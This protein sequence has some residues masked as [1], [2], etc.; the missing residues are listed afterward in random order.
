MKVQTIPLEA[1][2]AAREF[3]KDCIRNEP[4][5]PFHRDELYTPFPPRLQEELDAAVSGGD[6]LR[7]VMLAAKAEA[8]AACP[9]LVVDVR[10]SNYGI[11]I[12]MSGESEWI[13]AL[14]YA[15]GSGNEDPSAK[16]SP[17]AAELLERT[18]CGELSSAFRS[19]QSV[20]HRIKFFGYGSYFP[21]IIE[22]IRVKK[23]IELKQEERVEKGP[24]QRKL[25]RFSI[26]ARF[27]PAAPA[28]GYNPVLP[29]FNGQLPGRREFQRWFSTMLIEAPFTGNESVLVWS[30]RTRRELFRCFPKSALSKGNH[31]DRMFSLLS[32]LRGNSVYRVGWNLD[33]KAFD[34]TVNALPCGTWDEAK[35]ALKEQLAKPTSES[36]FGLSPPAAVL[37][38]W[39]M[40]L[41][42]SGLEMGL[43]PEVE[44][45]IRETRLL[46]D[47]PWASEN[48][49]LYLEL[50]AEEV[51]DRTP[52][53]LKVVDWQRSG[54]TYC[55]IRVKKR[56]S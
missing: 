45:E 29:E 28:Q 55:R 22:E 36:K 14:H 6:G 37:F 7:R 15:H 41:S 26:G 27:D 34:W 1:L 44:K 10:E 52:F 31:P 30:I 19:E 46:L 4:L 13:D 43:T 24:K 20:R 39:V 47:C 50:L 25:M 35:V 56:V 42:S 21:A 3:I 16:L 53:D 11:G 51:T 40:G 17:A 9:G 32:S 48:L 8:E 49:R 2:V 54:T 23:G 18:E 12:S 38:D 33:H 5:I